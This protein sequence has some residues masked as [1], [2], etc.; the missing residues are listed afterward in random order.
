MCISLDRLMYI[1]PRRVF[2]YVVQRTCTNWNNINTSSNQNFQNY[3]AHNA[4]TVA[5]KVEMHG[6]R[7]RV[8]RGEG[9]LGSSRLTGIWTVSVALTMGV[10]WDAWWSFCLLSHRPSWIGTPKSSKWAWIW[11]AMRW[12][13]SR[14]VS[15]G[16]TSS[17]GT[18]CRCIVGGNRMEW[19]R[20]YHGRECKAIKTAWKNR[21]LLPVFIGFFQKFFEKNRCLL[22]FSKIFVFSW[23]WATF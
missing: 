6:D 23:L 7:R 21:F 9:S 15:G 5:Q 2:I 13:R 16:T 3:H 20:L 19:T 11:S 18:P 8:Q 22:V 14:R 1:Y 12:R 4:I 17:S 10:N